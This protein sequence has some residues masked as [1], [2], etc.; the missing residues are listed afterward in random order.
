MVFPAI[1]NKYVYIPATSLQGDFATAGFKSG[2]EYCG[3]Y[4]IINLSLAC[5]VNCRLR[6]YQS[7][8]QSDAEETLLYDTTITA[9]N[10]FFKRFQIRGSY[11]SVELDNT[12]SAVDAKI[13]MYTSLSADTQFSAST[14]LNSRM[15]IDEDTSLVRVGNSYHN[16][17]VRGMHF[18]FS[19]VNIQGFIDSNNIGTNEITI[20]LP[21]NFTFIDT[22]VSTNIRVTGANDNFPAGTGARQIRLIGILDDGTAFDSIYNVNTGLGSTGLTMLCVNRMIVTAAGSLKHNEGLITLEESSGNTIIGQVLAEEN[23]S[24]V[25]V[26]KIAQDRQLI[27]RDVNIAAMAPSGK[28]RVIEMDPDGLEYTLGE[29]AITTTYQQL[30][31]NLDGLIPSGNIIKVNFIPDPGAPAGLVRINVNVNGVLCPE[32]NSYPNN[33]F[34]APAPPPPPVS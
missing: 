22:G 4:A 3:A 15:G 30:T 1:A 9:R 32:I 18:D 33:S 29:F 13:N 16:D 27:L 5:D 8:S 25:A 21:N 19:K 2:L 10:Y 7:P 31:Y 34:P 26:Y 12:T 23:S 14:F 24:H 20:G 11:F 28:I 17:L 6:I